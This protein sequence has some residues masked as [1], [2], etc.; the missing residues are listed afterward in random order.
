MIQLDFIIKVGCKADEGCFADPEKPFCSDNRC[1]GGCRVDEDCDCFDEVCNVPGYDN[2]NY[3]DAADSLSIGT[4]SP[5]TSRCQSQVQDSLS[6]FDTIT[7]SVPLMR[8]RCYLWDNLFFFCIDN[9][10]YVIVRKNIAWK[11]IN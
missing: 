5:G 11:C 4:C 1:Y 2:C 6:Q 3:C 10:F 8:N 9:F 7:K